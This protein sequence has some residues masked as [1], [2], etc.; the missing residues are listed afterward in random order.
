MRN[1]TRWTILIEW[2]DKG[3]CDA[4]EVVVIAATLQEAIARA[5]QTWRTTV[6]I[7]WPHCRIVRAYGLRAGG[8]PLIP[9]R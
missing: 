5:K 1:S 4:D 9:H 3:S 7:K 2:D 8:R 6:G